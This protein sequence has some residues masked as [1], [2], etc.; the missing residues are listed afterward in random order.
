MID[1]SR[2][3]PDDSASPTLGAPQI[4]LIAI[5]FLALAVESFDAFSI[6]FAAPSLI[7][8]WQISK[9]SLVPVFTANVAGLALGAFLFGAL[10]DRF[11]NRRTLIVILLVCGFL[12]LRRF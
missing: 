12:T 5:C 6:A 2:E 11:G 4:L 9:I 7:A 8:E 10:A 1:Q 3:L